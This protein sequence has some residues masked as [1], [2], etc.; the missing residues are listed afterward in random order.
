M[1]TVIVDNAVVGKG[2]FEGQFVPGAHEVRVTESGKA[3]Y[4]ANVELPDG[5]MRTMQVT[6]ENEGHGAICAWVAGGAG[7]VAGAAGGGYFLLKPQDQTV[8]V[9]SGTLGS[10]HFQAWRR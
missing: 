1:A 9:P 7:V 8:P 4:Q 5:E 6:L 10:R 3:P 2:H